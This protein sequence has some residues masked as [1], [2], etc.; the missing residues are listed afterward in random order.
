MESAVLNNIAKKFW[1]D[2]RHFILQRD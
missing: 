2:V 1:P